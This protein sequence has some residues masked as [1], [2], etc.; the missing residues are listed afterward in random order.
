MCPITSR[1]RSGCCQKKAEQN[2]DHNG[3]GNPTKKKNQG[4]WV[5]GGAVS[6]GHRVIV[7]S[8]SSELPACDCAVRSEI[9]GRSNVEP[10]LD[11]SF[12]VHITFPWSP[13]LQSRGPHHPVHHTHPSFLAQS[14]LNGNGSWNIGDLFS[15]ET[16]WRDCYHAIW[17]HGYRL[18]PRYDPD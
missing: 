2:S 13:L 9:L 5:K 18:R 6:K 4:K 12:T 11:Q 17:G 3:T 1:H 10:T 16:W 7:I 14:L 15:S 8:S